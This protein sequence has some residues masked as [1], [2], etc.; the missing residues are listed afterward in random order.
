MSR[1]INFAQRVEFLKIP[2][3]YLFILFKKKDVNDCADGP[4]EN[5]GNCTNAVNDYNCSCVAGYTGKNYSIG[6][7]ILFKNHLQRHC[8]GQFTILN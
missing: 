7:P 1:Y 3:H 5:G 8:I 4:C 6:K 2:N